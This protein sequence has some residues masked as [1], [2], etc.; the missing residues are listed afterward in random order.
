MNAQQTIERWRR[1]PLLLAY[2]NGWKVVFAMTENGTIPALDYMEGVDIES[3]P[4]WPFA[5]QMKRLVSYVEQVRAN[6]P[7]SLGKNQLTVF[8]GDDASDNMCELRLIAHLG[9]RIMGFLRLKTLVLTNGFHKE[10]SGTPH[11]QKS[12]A[13]EVLRSHEIR[14]AKLQGGSPP[15]PRKKGR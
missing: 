10:T 13:R 5:G 14:L 4:Q 7:F 15:T 6:G 1:D 2:S 8:K 9:H 12:R 3:D 11:E